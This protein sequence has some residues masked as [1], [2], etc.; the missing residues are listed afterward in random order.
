MPI[1]PQP[2]VHRV[3]VTVSTRTVLRVLAL[4][5]LFVASVDLVLSIRQILSWLFVSVFF[6]IALEPLVGW[7]EQR[8]MGRRLA[9]ALVFGLTVI[10][11]V[12]FLAAL[13][14]PLYDQVRSFTTDL[15]ANIHSLARWGPLKSHPELVQRLERDA[16]QLPEHLPSSA[17]SIFGIASQVVDAV[18]ALVT[19]L[20]LTLFILLE[21]PAITAF[22]LGLLAPTTA[23]RL[24]EMQRDINGAVV[25]YVACNLIVSVICALVTG[26]SLF[27]LGVPFAFVLALLSGFFDIVPLVGATIGGVIVCLVAFAH[28]TTAGIVMV[29]VYLVYQQ[30]ENHLIQPV[31]MRRGVQVSPL[32]TLVAVLVGSSLMGMVG[33]LLAIPV[34]ASVQI[35][36]REV[37]AERKR[38]VDQQ[39]ATLEGVEESDAPSSDSTHAYVAPAAG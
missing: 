17:G 9:V 12:A 34:A 27:L 25:N 14:T 36:L 26:I 4:C 35:A 2:N 33:A 3:Q 5:A 24:T 6:A 22:L 13:L 21:L 23:E 19:V 16:R 10:G 29:I 8:G 18:I 7:C 20:F 1:V 11:I 39:R 38:A 28:D 31:I 30:I 32:I 15:P 37:I